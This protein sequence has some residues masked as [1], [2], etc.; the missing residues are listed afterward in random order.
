LKKIP[1]IVKKVQQTKL[2]EIDHRFQKSLSYSQ[3]SIYK[4]CPH[5]WSLRYK[6][7]HYGDQPSIHT[8]FGTAIHETIQHYLTVFYNKSGA[9]ADRVE[10]GDFLQEHLIGEYKK[11]YKNNNNTHFSSSEELREFFDDGLSIINFLKEKR[12][13]YFS[14]RGWWL[15]GCEVPILLPLENN[16]Y[17]KGYIDLVLY[18]EKADMFYLYDI[19]T[20]TGGWNEK[21]KKDELKQFQLILYKK[22]FSEQYNIPLEKIDIEFFITRRKIWESSDYPINRIQEFKPP[23]GKIKLNKATKE[24]NEFIKDTYDKKGNPIEKEYPKK[25]S[26]NCQWCPFNERKDLCSK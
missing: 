22:F 21:A 7:G 9:E 1:S 6:E 17:F 3:F 2:P 12:G 13:R 8:L 15:V 26:N 5:R 24:F 20:S 25:V 10:M 23:A 14:K 16:L 11:Q 4:G 18:S 19:K